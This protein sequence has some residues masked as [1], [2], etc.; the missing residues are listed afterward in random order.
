MPLKTIPMRKTNIFAILL[1]TILMSFGTAS[2]AGFIVKK[3]MT[4]SDSTTTVSTTTVSTKQSERAANYNTLKDYAVQHMGGRGGE[5]G[6]GSGWEGIV[7]LCTG[8]LAFFPGVFGLST[9]LF[10]ISAIVF[11]ALGMNRKKRHHGMAIAG[12]VLGI[13]YFLIV[14]LAVIFVL[15]FF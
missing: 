6:R 5:P 1:L 11:G 12:L 3:Q 7:S 4:M 13:L 9:L 15:S 10:A 2:Y 14:A 8:I